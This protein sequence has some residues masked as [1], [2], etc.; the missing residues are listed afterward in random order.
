[1]PGPSLAPRGAVLALCISVLVSIYMSMG[2]CGIVQQRKSASASESM[3]QFAS[4]RQRFLS[5]KQRLRSGWMHAVGGV[6]YLRRPKQSI[7]NRPIPSFGL[8]LR[9]DEEE[10]I[11]RAEHYE[12]LRASVL[13][14]VRQTSKSE[15]FDAVRKGNDLCAAQEFSLHEYSEGDKHIFSG[16]REPEETRS[17]PHLALRGGGNEDM[18]AMPD[19]FVVP[20]QYL[21]LHGAVAEA[22]E[23]IQNVSD[24]HSSILIRLGGGPD[25]YRWGVPGAEYRML[26]IRGAL[27]IRAAEGVEVSGPVIFSE[28]SRGEVYKYAA[29]SFS[30][31]RTRNWDSN[32]C[33]SYLRIAFIYEFVIFAHVHERARVFAWEPR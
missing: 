22:E 15:K 17:R 14:A 27:K 3:S 1:M 29:L 26:E 21:T 16:S 8:Q 31:F 25:T 19:D 9:S 5:S 32:L 4:S 13:R 24:K 33:L 6:Q 30:G 18:L 23:A 10:K 20:E 28:S 2:R 7:K 11:V 12:R